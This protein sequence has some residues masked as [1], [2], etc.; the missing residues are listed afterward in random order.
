MRTRLLTSALLVALAAPFALADDAKSADSLMSEAFSRAK[1]EKKAVF[2]SFH[3]SWCGWCH[4]LEDFLKKPEIKTIWDKRVV[5]VWLTVMENGDKKVNE[6]PGGMDWLKKIDGD[7][8]GIPFSAFFS[9]DGKMLV[10]SRDQSPEGK[11]GNIGYPA[12]PN[13]IAWF[14]KMIEKGAPNITKAE[15]SVIEAALKA[16]AK[17]LGR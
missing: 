2:L 16:E 15:R 17:K 9:T 4:K 12:A 14:M 11:N 3:A 1:A 10:N 13:E 5:M 7:S 6:N 8:Q